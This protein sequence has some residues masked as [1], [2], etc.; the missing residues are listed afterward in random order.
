MR[1]PATPPTMHA[2]PPFRLSLIVAPIAFA[3]AAAPL[4]GCTKKEDP[5]PTV[6]TTTSAAPV[7]RSDD[8]LPPPPVAEVDAGAPAPTSAGPAVATNAPP[9]DGCSQKCTGKSTPE[10]ESTL[11]GMARRARV[12]YEQALKNDP[13]LKGHVT[14][15]VKIGAN[16]STCGASVA[17]SDF[18]DAS[19]GACSANKFRTTY[20]APKGGCVEVS[21]PLNFTTR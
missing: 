21:Q 12:C 9:S 19:I 11:A 15:K 13:A 20:P 17:S 1:A 6:T 5:K 10:L 2:L 18:S 8:D 7:R 3:L 4:V 14:I 16:G